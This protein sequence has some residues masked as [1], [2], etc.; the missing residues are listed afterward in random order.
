MNEIKLILTLDAIILCVLFLVSFFW[1]E[2]DRYTSMNMY[3]LGPILIPVLLFIS[4]VCFYFSNPRLRQFIRVMH[5]RW[6][7]RD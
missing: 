4:F 7:K 6:F 2:I 5:Y 1:R 3:A